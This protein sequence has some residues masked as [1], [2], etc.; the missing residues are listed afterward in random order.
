[1]NHNPNENALNEWP[2]KERE[3]EKKKKKEKKRSK[4]KTYPRSY[5]RRLVDEKNK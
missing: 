5:G 1:M 3:R 2:T 4:K